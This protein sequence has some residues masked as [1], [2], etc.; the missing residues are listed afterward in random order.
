MEAVST[1]TG[2][3]IDGYVMINISG[4]VKLIDD[5]GGVDINVPTKVYDN[6]CGPAGTW[7]SKHRVCSVSPPHD[8]YQVPPDTADVI[9]RMK[10]DA[11]KSGDGPP[12]C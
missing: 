4:L 12:Q 11:A 9:D 8:G 7:E 6:P 2:L 3:V 5:L 1:L 10:A